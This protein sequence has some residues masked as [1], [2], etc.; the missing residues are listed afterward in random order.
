MKFGTIA[1]PEQVAAMAR[2]L[3]AYC[4]QAGI[5]S[6]VERENLAAQIMALFEIGVCEEDELLAA[7]IP[8]PPQPGSGGSFDPRSAT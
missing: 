8:P 6:Q 1:S 4:K 3:D 5:T 2:V 7:L